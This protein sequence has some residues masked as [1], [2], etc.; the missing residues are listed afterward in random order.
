MVQE[1]QIRGFPATFSLPRGKSRAASDL[2]LG[3]QIGN[4]HT[5]TATGSPVRTALIKALASMKGQDIENSKIAAMDGKGNG[6]TEEAALALPAGITGIPNTTGH[7]CFLSTVIQCLNA[8]DTFRSSLH[9]CK[10]RD[11]N[12]IEAHLKRLVYNGLWGRSIVSDIR[13]V[14]NFFASVMRAT[15]EWISAEGCW[16]AKYQKEKGYDTNEFYE[17]LMSVLSS[18]KIKSFS[19]VNVCPSCKAQE[20]SPPL[21]F[22][23]IL[24]GFPS[25]ENPASEGNIIELLSLMNTFAILSDQREEICAP[26]VSERNEQR[27]F[28]R[29]VVELPS[30]LPI[31]LARRIEG[32]EDRH[33]TARVSIPRTINAGDL[34]FVQ[35]LASQ[36]STVYDLKGFI[37][38]VQDTI[39]TDE[40][41]PVP[42]GIVRRE[43]V[44]KCPHHIAI[45]RSSVNGGFYQIDD[46]RVL[47]IGSIDAYLERPAVQGR[48]TMLF[49]ERR[50][51]RTVSMPLAGAS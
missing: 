45:V 6:G 9:E 30:I 12:T 21:S 11:A 48:V 46:S 33:N 7:M 16:I 10:P 1:R 51:E 41:R 43:E 50:E 42:S 25:L 29:K 17:D 26:C 44:G 5:A 35:I 23:Q 49:Y 14:D 19:F 38:H 32:A 34:P 4:T 24:L 15:K 8:C 40:I 47:S 39:Q 36:G 22:H 13:L 31:A 2:S 37:V 18:L 28:E 27:N 20:D 3:Q